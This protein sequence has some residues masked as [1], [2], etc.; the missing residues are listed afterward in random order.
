MRNLKR[1]LSLGLS[2]GMLIS[3]MVMGSGAAGYDDVTTDYNVEAIEVL[4]AVGVMVG[5]ENGNFNPDAEVTRNE[6]AVIMS[7][8]MDYR[9][10]TYAGTS[11]FTDVPSWAEPYVAACWTNGI[12]AGY[13]DT[14]YG[15]GDTVT[16][17]QAALML[18]KALGYFQYASDFGQ[19][20]QLATVQQGTQIGLFNDV[21]AGV[22]E[23]MTRNDVAQLVLNT[24][25][26]TLVEPDDNVINVD[27][28]DV[29][30]SAGKITYYYR[31]D[32][33]NN[34]DYTAIGNRNSTATGINGTQGTTIEL[35]EELY[36][37]DLKRTTGTRDAY[38]RPATRWVYGLNEIGAYADDPIATYTAKVSK[39]ELYSLITKS[40]LDDISNNNSATDEYTFTVYAD[41]DDVV[42]TTYGVGFDTVRPTYFSSNSSAAAGT[43]YTNA[44]AGKG[45]QTEVYLDNDGNLT[46]VYI[47]TYVM[48]ATDDYNVDKGT[49][50]VELLTAPQDFYTSL[51]TTQHVNT[52]QLL[53][54]DFDLVDYR[55]DD[56][57]LY[58]V[59]NG[60]VEDIYPA[61]IATGEVTAYSLESSV[62]L[63]NT[64]YDY[65]AKIDGAKTSSG[66]SASDSCAT[67]YRVGDTA[68]VVL[69]S[70]GYVVYVDSAAIS[71]GNYVYITDIVARSGLQSNFIAKGYFTDGTT[72]EIT[73]NKIRDNDDND[74]SSY[75]TDGDGE[76]S[77]AEI[78]TAI[79]GAGGVPTGITSSTSNLAGWYSYSINSS[80][81][82]TLNLAET[83]S[84]VPSVT[85]LVNEKVEFVS[86]VYGNENTVLIVD[87]GDDVKV[88]VGIN[89]FPTITATSPSNFSV[90][91][92]NEKDSKTSTYAAVAFVD[93]SGAG[94]TVD[95]NSNEVLM[96]VLSRSSRYVDSAEN[97]TIE[98]WNVILN[99]EETT[100][101]AKAGDLSAYTLYGRVKQDADGYYS[102]DTFSS[103]TGSKPTYGTSPLN[104]YTGAADTSVATI[105]V[106]GS[107]L[108]VRD[109][110]GAIADTYVI[111]G[112]TQIVVVLR[113]NG[114]ATYD[115]LGQMMVDGD[116]SYEVQLGLTATRLNTLLRN[117]SIRGSYST[118]VEESGS[119]VLETLIITVNEARDL[120]S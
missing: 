75:D 71:L 82:Y 27:T 32:H 47:N 116:A 117:Y 41:G 43:S 94:I 51:A 38:G 45:V 63:D 11:P 95:D 34:S 88:Y 1:V 59:S 12:T 23:T 77:S 13:S 2:A 76:L 19:D 114:S 60:Q 37:G 4:Q 9:V 103:M 3:M 20:W 56:Y 10:A 102:G 69:D 99:G 22:R 26:A 48:Q 31:V 46:L 87:D 92:F 120:R 28:G 7:N 8:L 17:A 61:E 84:T 81:E 72:A 65:A 108:I 5:D 29:S 85:S 62:T 73:L 104:I 109:S 97:E 79:S 57:I 42:S 39:G 16:T 15:G 33:T 49:L 112:D 96:Y 25:E 107:S 89:N 119:K 55:E 58:T 68:V 118:I 40:T 80:D 98:V 70:N 44:V 66:G 6:M 78:S 115:D 54:D 90:N 36:S 74:L 53:S 67:E 14:T 24:L 101:E 50:S 30:V 111:T 64:K 86:G 18:M 91:F 35:G 106:N 21:E 100:V 110:T 93:A 83:D 113:P 52:T 105:S